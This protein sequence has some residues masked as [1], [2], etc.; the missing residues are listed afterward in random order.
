MTTID[1]SLLNAIRVIV[2]E[3]VAPLGEKIDG[4]TERVDGLTTRIER[5]ETEQ[6]LQRELLYSFQKNID[7]RFT[8]FQENIDERFARLDLRLTNLEGISIRLE[9][10]I[11]TIETRTGQIYSDVIDLLELQD[12]VNEGFNKFKKEIQQAFIDMGAVQDSQS[13]YQRQVKQLRQRVDRL[14]Q[15]L[16]KLEGVGGAHE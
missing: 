7:E 14:E 9:N 3:A 11:G 6:Q 5:V 8:R 16:S 10:E 4:L 13:G 12:K 1:Q 2:G 15:R